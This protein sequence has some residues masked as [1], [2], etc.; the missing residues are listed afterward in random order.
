[1]TVIVEPDGDELHA[2]CPAC[3]GLHVRGRTEQ[4]DRGHPREA[5]VLRLASLTQ[6]GD[7]LP[8]G[9]HV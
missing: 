8:V 7:P 1:V 5:L 2:Y 4:E 9:P 6:C 3:K